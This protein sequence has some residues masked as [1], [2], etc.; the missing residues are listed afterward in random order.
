MY[1]DNLDS[2]ELPHLIYSILLLAALVSSFIF[3]S[4]LKLFK[5]VKQVLLW[6]LIGLTIIVLYSFRYD[7]YNLKNRIITE[8]FPSKAVMIND[9]QFSVNSSQNGHFYV[10]LNVNDAPIKF[11]VDTGASDL[12]LNAK[13]AKKVGIDINKLRFSKSYQTANGIILVA[14]THVKEI[15]ISGLKFYDAPVSV[16]NVDMGISLLGI[17]FLQKFKKYEFY[18]NKLI[19]TY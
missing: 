3:R 7:F 9:R 14:S 15:E 13:D 4:N 1:F 17:R 19:L 18:Q 2:S 16:S 12:V 11:M 6:I 5:L 10:Y 8:L